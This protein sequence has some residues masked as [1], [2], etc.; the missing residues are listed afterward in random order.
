MADSK[1]DN[2]T[3]Q[4]AAEIAAEEKPEDRVKVRIPRGAEKGDPNVFVGINGKNY[5]LPRGKTS[6]VPRFVKQE[7][8]RSEQAAIDLDDDKNTMIN[9]NI[10]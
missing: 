8:D 6:E 10:K 9:E 1:K 3:E 4:A 7:L 2:S 5:I